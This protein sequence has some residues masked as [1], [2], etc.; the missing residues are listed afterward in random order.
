M[1]KFFIILFTV[2]ALTASSQ[3]SLFLA[4]EGPPRP[5]EDN[6]VELGMVFMPKVNGVITH[7]RFYKT[8]AE[9]A[10]EY[11]LN[12]WNAYGGNAV[13]QKISAPGRGGWI[14]VAL[15]TPARVSAGS[16]YVVSVHFAKGRYGGRSSVF[17]SA[18]VRGNLTAPSTAQ[19][20]GNGRYIYGSTTAFPTK[21]YNAS[22]YYVD[23]VFSPERKT[24]I[25]NAGRDTTLVTPINGMVG[26]YML[27][28][29]VDGDDVKFTWRKEWPLELAD[30]M[31]NANTLTPI[32]RDLAALP[33]RYVL[34]GVDKWGTISEHMVT[35]NVVDNP[36]SVVMILKRDGQTFIEIYQDGSWRQVTTTGITGLWFFQGINSPGFDGDIIEEPPPR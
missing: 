15:T 3:D 35:V 20:G 13:L 14:R 10:S 6:P 5:E 32:L 22:S 2:L 27:R 8:A 12:L 17:S 1:H 30:T 26:D 16:Y 7:F 25:V 29:F 34:R 33:H 21:T 11:T 36:K 28:G 23:V 4:S 31:L 9:D 24:L 19:A 18:R